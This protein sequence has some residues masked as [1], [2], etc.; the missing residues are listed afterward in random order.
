[1]GY[2]FLIIGTGLFGSVFAREATDKGYKCLVI[3]KRD[4]IGGN[5]YTHKMYNIDIHRYGPHIFHTNSDKVWNYVNRFTEFESYEH[6]VLANYKG[7]IYNLPFNLNTFGQLFGTTDVDGLKRIIEAERFK[8]MPTNLEEQALSMVGHTVYETLIKGYTQ[9][10]WNQHPRELPKS[11]ITRLPVRWTFNNNYF[12]DT[13]Q[14]IPKEGYTKI[15]HKLL[16]GCDL[17]LDIDY[18]NSREEFDS[19]AKKI[20]YT[21]PIDRFYDYCFGRLDYRSLRFEHS[22]IN[23]KYFQDAAQINFTSTNVP[24]TRIIEHKRFR[25]NTHSYKTIITKEFPSNNLDEPYYP[26]NNKKNTSIYEQYKNIKKSDKYIF[27]GRL[28]EYRY[29]DMDQTIASALNTVYKVLGTTNK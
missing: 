5:C 24:Y 17:Y 13:Y 18:F 19:L 16:D 29:Y 22:I 27:G 15:F 25:K 11:I 2:D 1:M 14:G 3:D 23:D 8:G 6:N 7:T 4:H 26:I 21:G 20:I 10:Q 28:A 12:N 9:K